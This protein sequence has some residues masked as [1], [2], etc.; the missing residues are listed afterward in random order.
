MVVSV[1]SFC[2]LYFLAFLRHNGQL[3]C[4]ASQF[5]QQ[6]LIRSEEQ[7]LL[8][9]LILGSLH[10]SH[11]VGQTQPSGYLLQDRFGWRV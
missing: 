1:L 3:G 5:P 6:S 10:L 4:I 9:I 2:C 8:Q 11:T 7:F